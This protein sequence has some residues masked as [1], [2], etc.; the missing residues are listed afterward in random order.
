MWMTIDNG[1]HIS[2]A[3][4]EAIPVRCLAFQIILNEIEVLRVKFTIECCLLVTG[5]HA[6]FPDLF[7]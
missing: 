3:S 5:L 4:R 6:F 2:R 7:L 1:C